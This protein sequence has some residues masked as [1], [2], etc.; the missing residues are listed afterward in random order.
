MAFAKAN[1]T[2]NYVVVYKRTGED[3]SVQKVE[4]PTITPVSVN[5]DNQSDFVK[6]IINGPTKDIEPVFIDYN[7]DIQKI[8]LKNN[9]P[10]L[11]TANT[12]N[13]TF[14]MFYILDMGTN[15]NNKLDVAVNYLKYLGTKDLSAAALQQEFYKLGCSF[16]VY[17]GDKSFVPRYFK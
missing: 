14:E 4:K 8:S 9:I 13:K 1:Y 15:N 12:E 10:L 11:Y 6:N 5:R 16:D 17:A 7:K 2:N 3:K